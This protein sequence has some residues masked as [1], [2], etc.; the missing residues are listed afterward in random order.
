MKFPAAISSLR[1]QTGFFLIECLVYLAL[2]ALLL[3]LGLAAFYFCWDH[4]RAVIFATD[5]IAAALNAGERWRADVRSATGKIS[6]E[7]TATGEIVRI[8]EREKEVD[9]RFE[10]GEMRREF[11]AF[12]TS[13]LLLPKVK[14]STMETELR[15]GVTAWRWELELT[16]HRKETRLPLLFTFEAAQTRP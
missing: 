15:G 13:L 3:G 5:D 6:I 1:R 8:P 9:Y 12:K 7:T 14:A 4:S 16:P 2:F 10:S 11:P